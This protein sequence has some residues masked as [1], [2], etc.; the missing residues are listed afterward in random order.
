VQ[1]ID[2]R[3]L[4]VS[5]EPLCTWLPGTGLLGIGSLGTELPGHSPFRKGIGSR[6]FKP[7][8][9]DENGYVHP[10]KNEIILEMQINLTSIGRRWIS[11][12]CRQPEHEKWKLE[13]SIG[14]SGIRVV[15]SSRM[16][17]G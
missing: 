6:G 3:G 8:K 12:N 10:Q 9:V 15:T 4:L 16:Y 5:Q 1:V 17:Q 13:L 7:Q 2:Y 14:R 11:D